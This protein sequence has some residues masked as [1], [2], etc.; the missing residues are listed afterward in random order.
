[1]GGGR[2]YDEARLAELIMFVANRV[3]GDSMFGLTKVNK[4]I[5]FADFE[6]YRRTGQSITGAVYQRLDQG[7][8]AHQFMPALESLGDDVREVQRQ[9]PAGTRRELVPLRDAKVDLF[10]GPEIA[11]VDEIIDWF[12]PMTARQASDQS[13]ET[14]AYRLT[15]DRDEVPY[16]A[17]VLSSDRPSVEDTAWLEEVAR[18]E[19]LVPAPSD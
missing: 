10:T 4:V 15:Y 16:G 8:C 18:R 3:L 12:R 17:A 13:H 5:F 11:L 19:G 7:P 2:K 9:T 14:M 6:A 1:M